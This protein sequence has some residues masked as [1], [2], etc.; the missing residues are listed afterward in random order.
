MPRRPIG[1]PV[2]FAGAAV[3]LLAACGDDDGETSGSEARTIE[4]EMRDIEFVPD[5]IQVQ[6][7]ETVQLVFRNTG[8]VAHDA[9]IGD[10]AAQNQHEAD[11]REVDDEGSG[12]DHE[13]GG[14]AGGDGAP[15]SSPATP[16][17]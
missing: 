14:D 16:A 9:F 12:M 17:S 1:L 4:I 7:G 6:A 13:G 11:M 2:A 10:D 5:E 15:L 8:A 3:L